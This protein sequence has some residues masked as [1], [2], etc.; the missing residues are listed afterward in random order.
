MTEGDRAD[1]AL[2]MRRAGVS[3]RQIAQVLGYE[4]ADAV[5]DDVR[6][7]SGGMVRV[8]DERDLD[9]DRL[10]RLLVGLWQRATS[11]EDPAATKLAKEII[12][13]RERLLGLRRAPRQDP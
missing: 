6:S 10:D 5:R 2:S 1:R 3:L 8:E 4:D 7:A 9:A 11:G 12:E 13:V